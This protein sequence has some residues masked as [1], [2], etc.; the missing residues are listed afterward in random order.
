MKTM[1]KILTLLLLVSCVSKKTYQKTVSEYQTQDSL[2]TAQINTL[3]DSI[4]TFQKDSSF[5][6][7]RITEADTT[8]LRLSL[9]SICDSIVAIKNGTIVDLKTK[10]LNLSVKNGEIIV[11]G[12]TK[13]QVNERIFQQTS[14][15]KERYTSKIDSISNYYSQNTS[16]TKIEN[17]NVIKV[18]RN[19]FPWWV[20]VISLLLNLIYVR[21]IFD[22]LVNRFYRI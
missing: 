19:F 9:K 21:Q 18:K 10:N 20:T 4:S 16:N 6:E 5:V 11:K 22:W 14:L 12:F 3:R 8:E 13:E 15:I 17:T 1:L 2:K 7:R